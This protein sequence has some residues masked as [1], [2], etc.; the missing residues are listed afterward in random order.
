[1]NNNVCSKELSIALFKTGYKQEGLFR[2]VNC[3]IDGF[4]VQYRQ[5]D[6]YGLENIVAPTPTELGERLPV[7]IGDL[8]LIICKNKSNIWFVS[9]MFE[10]EIDFPTDTVVVQEVKYQKTAN[11]LAQAMGKMMLYLLKEGLLK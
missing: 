6:V 11:T 9:Y 4:T 2:W 3:L 5:R 1:M 7:N 10:N 8:D